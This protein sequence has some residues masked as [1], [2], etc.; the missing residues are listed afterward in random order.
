M[1]LIRV[2]LFGR[3]DIVIQFVIEKFVSC[4]FRKNFSVGTV[5]HYDDLRPSTNRLN[6]R[7]VQSGALDSGNSTCDTAILMLRLETLSYN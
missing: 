6:L 7:L 3:P 1:F 2:P 5:I 4:L